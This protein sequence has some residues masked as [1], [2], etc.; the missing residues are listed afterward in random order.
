MGKTH[1]TLAGNSSQADWRYLLNSFSRNDGDHH[2]NLDAGCLWKSSIIIIWKKH[3]NI[4]MTFPA[5]SW[6][7]EGRF[8]ATPGFIPENPG[9]IR[10]VARTLVMTNHWLGKNRLKQLVMMSHHTTGYQ[11][12]LIPTSWGCLS[13]CAKLNWIPMKKHA[14]NSIWNRYGYFCGVSGKLSYM[15]GRIHL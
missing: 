10:E 3:E 1:L 5:T 6:F 2:L 11:L 7:L 14:N 9:S 13:V 4:D 8:I 12:A 15:T